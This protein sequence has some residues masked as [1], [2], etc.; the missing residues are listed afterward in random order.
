M[1]E[2]KPYRVM[3]V[4]NDIK[5]QA[6]IDE[7]KEKLMIK[8]TTQLFRSA[9]YELHSKTFKDYLQSKRNIQHREREIQEDNTKEQ[10][11]EICNELGGRLMKDERGVEVCQFKTYNKVGGNIFDGLQTIEAT[12][13]N[14]DH[15]DNQFIGG[16]KEEILKLYEEQENEEI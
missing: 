9:L 14:Q 10:I 2:K 12:K 3:L 11:K 4:F 16:S 8:H 13:L 15:I 6:M 1:I 5:D 7:L